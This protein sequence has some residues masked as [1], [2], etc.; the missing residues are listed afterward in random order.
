[1]TSSRQKSSLPMV[2]KDYAAELER[3]DREL[4]IELSH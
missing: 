2:A 4:E 1:M 3:I